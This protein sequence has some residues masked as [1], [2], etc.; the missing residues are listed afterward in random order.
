VNICKKK[1]NNKMKH[2]KKFSSFKINENLMQGQTKEMVLDIRSFEINVDLEN[3]VVTKVNGDDI[4]QEDIFS[5]DEES[6]QQALEPLK[7]AGVEVR[8]EP[9]EARGFDDIPG[10]FTIDVKSLNDAIAKGK[11]TIEVD[12]EDSDYLIITKVNGKNV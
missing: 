9:W 8:Y 6:F 10:W 1:I 2:I 7:D 3:N 4:E 5:Y 11:I 12:K